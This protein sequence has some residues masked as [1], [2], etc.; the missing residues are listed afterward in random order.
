MADTDADRFALGIGWLLPLTAPVVPA[1]HGPPIVGR[2]ESTAEAKQRA[3][4]RVVGAI[5]ETTGPTSR[6]LGH[7]GG[8]LPAS[9]ASR[10]FNTSRHT[11][12]ESRS[13]VASRRSISIDACKNAPAPCSRSIVSAQPHSSASRV[14]RWALSAVDLAQLAAALGL[15]LAILFLARRRICRS[16]CHGRHARLRSRA[17]GQ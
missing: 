2:G 1:R 12:A 16:R 11:A 10:R 3:I 5:P 8:A 14:T 7:C 13:P 15:K 9:S 17:Y 6:P 4:N